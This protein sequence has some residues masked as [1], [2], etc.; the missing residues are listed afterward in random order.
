VIRRTHRAIDSEGRLAGAAVF[1]AEDGFG[2]PTITAK[3]YNPVKH[4]HHSL[5]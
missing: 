2:K 3:N 5:Q 4:L 1:S